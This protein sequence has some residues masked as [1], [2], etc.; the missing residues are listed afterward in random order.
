[1]HKQGEQPSLTEL[2]LA[3][4][5]S[6]QEFDIAYV[7]LDAADESKPREDLLRVL[8]ELASDA[9]FCTRGLHSS[10]GQQTF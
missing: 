3:L 9:R 4:E 10:C 7:I 6:L 8:R 5:T 1:M 2:L